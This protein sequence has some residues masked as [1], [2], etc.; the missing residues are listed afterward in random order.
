MLLLQT[1]HCQDRVMKILT[2]MALRSRREKGQIRELFEITDCRKGLVLNRFPDRY[3]DAAFDVRWIRAT[4]II[5]LGEQP[6]QDRL[7]IGIIVAE[8]LTNAEFLKRLD[9]RA[10]DLLIIDA[11]KIINPNEKN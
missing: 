8:E 7:A 10:A 11:K 1:Y 4:K 2:D 6:G 5:K 9:D 3:F